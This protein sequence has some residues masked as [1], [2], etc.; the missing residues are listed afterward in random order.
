MLRRIRLMLLTV[1]HSGLSSRLE[2]I[3]MADL[4]QSLSWWRFYLVDGM[5]Q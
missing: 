1:K 3:L 2:L 4:L 5:G